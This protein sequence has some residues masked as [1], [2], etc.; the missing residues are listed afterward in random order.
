MSPFRD[1]SEYG[2]RRRVEGGVEARSRRGAFGTTWWGRALIDAV[3]N[4]ADAG[5]L[6]RGRTY[7][8]AGQVI[9]FRVGTGAVTAEVQGSQPQPFEST[10]FLRALDEDAVA[11]LIAQVRA[12]P[13]MLAEIVSG[14]L[15]ATLGPLLLPT[16]AGELDF[17]CTCPDSG[18]PCKHVAAVAYLTAEHLDKYPLDILAIRGVE[19]D[20]LISGV[21]N[22]KSIVD[23]DDLYGDRT[24]LPALPIVP[25]RPAIEDLDPAL[26]RKAMRQ[27]AADE[28]A[29]GAGIRE[30]EGLYGRLRRS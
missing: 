24:V 5:R 8:R 12:T 7:A 4:L 20:N 21:E 10:F 18:W 26:L 9:A 6:S 22:E 23:D 25:Q 28:R 16:S 30:L 14:S 1:F 3:E 29:V 13:G 11:E 17:D 2:P 19:L 27:L 15:P